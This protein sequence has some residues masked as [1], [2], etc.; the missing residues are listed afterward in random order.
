[1]TEGEWV[2][3]AQSQ[4]PD[5]VIIYEILKSGDVRPN[6]KQYFERYVLQ[7]GVIFRKTDMGNKWVVPRVSRRIVVK[8]CH[9]DQGHFALEETLE[10]I[11]ENYWFKGM[12]K[13]VTEYLNA[14]LNC[15]GD[16]SAK[17]PGPEFLDP[18]EK[19]ALP[20]H[21]I[22][23]DHG[24]PFMQSSHNNTHI[25]MIVDGYT[26]F[27]ILDPVE[28]TST[29]ETIKALNQFF[30]IF[31]VP[32][33]IISG[34][35]NTFTSCE[36][37]QF[38]LEREI[39]HILNAV[40]TP[41]HNEQCKRVNHVILHSL[42]TI[43]EDQP[44]NL[45]DTGVKSVQSALNCTVNRTTKKSPAQLLFGCKLRSPADATLLARIRDVLN[46]LDL[47]DDG[48]QAMATTNLAQDIREANFDAHHSNTPQY[49][50]GDVV[51]VASTPPASDES[52]TLAAKAKGPFKVMAV[53]SDDHCE[54]QDLRDPRNF[55]KLHRIV[56]VDRLKRW[57]R[58]DEV[59]RDG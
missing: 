34:R 10:K 24:G 51:M 41:R 38:C 20:F 33:Q 40:A 5:I 30:A 39:K 43:C 2:K 28:N 18:S 7:R 58:F 3:M 29:K 1:M 31:G 35:G 57:V 15:N 17:W 55:P 37:K 13:F 48:R 4:D 54:V 9:D 26:E 49:T 59:Q 14:C 56:T 6:T 44:E 52:S 27:C 53:L 16:E 45:W 23:L 8:I 32:S 12:R 50:V 11:R 42:K 21:T 25:L 36:F 22:H 19:V 47:K 46:Q